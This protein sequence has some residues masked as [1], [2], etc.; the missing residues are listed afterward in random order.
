MLYLITSTLSLHP[1]KKL[2]T[3]KG[4]PKKQILA[5]QVFLFPLN[6]TKKELN[7]FSSFFVLFE[8]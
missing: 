4:V 7:S 3:F 5:L 8:V 1:N 2:K 6:K